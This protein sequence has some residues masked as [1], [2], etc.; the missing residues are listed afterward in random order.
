MTTLTDTEL[1]ELIEQT[2]E[3][4]KIQRCVDSNNVK[5]LL[6]TL[7]QKIDA[8][9]SLLRAIANSAELLGQAL[10]RLDVPERLLDDL[11]AGSFDETKF[12]PGPWELFEVGDK[13]K[14]LCPS[15]NGTS[16][17]TVSLEYT[18]DGEPEYFGSVYYPA[19]AHLIAAAPDMYEAL[20]MAILEYGKPGGPW[21]VPSSPG[22]WIYKAKAAIVKARGEK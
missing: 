14:H 8:E 11:E 9:G 13:C 12:T 5:I 6:E 10:D 7:R 15:K 2:E 18:D 19:D 20:E 3:Q 4:C 16:I 1:D 22:T 21:N 17:L